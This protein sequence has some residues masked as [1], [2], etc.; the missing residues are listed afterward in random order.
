MI[1][2][3]RQHLFRN[4]RL[5][6][7]GPFVLVLS[8]AFLFFAFTLAFAAHISE[9]FSTLAFLLLFEDQKVT[10]FPLSSGKNINEIRLSR[11]L[12]K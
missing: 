2:W 7:A 6:F 11:E 10:F 8:V 5:A 3:G 12:G 9:Q 1:I 4:G